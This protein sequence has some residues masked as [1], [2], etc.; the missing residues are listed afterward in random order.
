DGKFLAGVSLKIHLWEV[1]SGKDLRQWGDSGR[2]IR[3]LVFSPDGRQIA[4]GDQAHGVRLYDVATGTESRVFSTQP[5]NQPYGMLM[6][7]SPDGKTLATGGEDRRVQLWDISS[8]AEKLALMGHS[9]RILGLAWSPDG[10]RILTGSADKTARLWD[11]SRGEELLKLEGHQKDVY[12]VAF[13]PDGRQMFT[14]DYGATIRSWDAVTGSPIRTLASERRTSNRIVFSPDGK[15]FLQASHALISIH[16]LSTGKDLVPAPGHLREIQGLV[17]SRDGRRI[18]SQ[19]G[20]DTVRSWLVESKEEKSRVDDHVSAGG[21]IA[22]SGDGRWLAVGTWDDIFLRDLSQEKEVWRI[23][24]RAK[25]TISLAFSPD[26]KILAWAVGLAMNKEDHA[27]HLMNAATGEEL[28]SMHGHQGIVTMLAFSAD[29]Q[30]LASAGAGYHGDN[31]IRWWDVSTGNELRKCEVRQMD[32]NQRYLRGYVCFTPDLSVIGTSDDRGLALRD[33]ATGKEFARVE[34]GNGL[35]VS[36]AVFSPD[37]RFLALGESK[38]EFRMPGAAPAPPPVDRIRFWEVATASELGAFEAGQGR[39][40]ALAFS[41]DGR[42]A[43]SGGRDT[44]ILIWDLGHLAGTGHPSSDPAGLWAD[45]ADP[46]GKKAWKAMELFVSRGDAV[47][48]MLAERLR[49]ARADAPRV[50]QW[51]SDLSSP[52]PAAQLKA[53]KMIGQSLELEGTRAEI[54]KA[55]DAKPSEELRGRLEAFLA[56][57]AAPAGAQSPEELRRGRVLHILETLGT[58]KAKDLLRGIAE[59]DPSRLSRDARSA[60][61]RI[62]SRAGEGR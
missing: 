17:F 47:L 52:S 33:S 10:R 45:L 62:E 22:L 54:Q 50:R 14:A 11:A 42:I 2:Q 5:A 25:G 59:G 8:G 60:L 38:S 40:E 57:S 20:D 51:I 28:R 36:A 26:G 23:K 44:T 48:G 53:S 13:S 34:C 39:I 35:G 61:A 29:G 6:S 49:P 9:G 41:P 3:S 4:A 21:S 18:Y 19:G 56:G 24:T 12:S 15:K 46:D 32:D 31:S 58:P 43:A 30:T 37:G 27:V 7:Y 55:L 16:D 1:A